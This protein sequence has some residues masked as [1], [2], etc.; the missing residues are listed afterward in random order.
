MTDDSTMTLPT[1]EGKRGRDHDT[2]ATP[3]PSPNPKDKKIP[4][5]GQG[6]KK[7]DPTASDLSEIEEAPNSA[8]S[9]ASNLATQ[10]EE[11]PVEDFQT[12]SAY[13]QV[14]EDT[15]NTHDNNQ[16]SN[17]NKNTND[18]KIKNNDDT[19]AAIAEE[20]QM[21]VEEIVFCLDFSHGFVNPSEAY[22]KLPSD[23]KKHRTVFAS[24]DV[25]QIKK[26][27]DEA[28]TTFQLPVDTLLPLSVERW[29]DIFADAANIVAKKNP[30]RKYKA[31]GLTLA[32]TH[33]QDILPPEAF[34]AGRIAESPIACA[35]GG[36]YHFFGCLWTMDKDTLI[37]WM[38]QQIA[39]TDLWKTKLPIKA[40]NLS[41][42]FKATEIFDESPTSLHCI[43]A[44]MAKVMQM[45]KRDD[46][47][48]WAVKI[49]KHLNSTGQVHL[50]RKGQGT[51]KDNFMR[52]AKTHPE[53]FTANIVDVSKLTRSSMTALWTA[54]YTT[55]GG[56]WMNP[57]LFEPVDTTDEGFTL[58]KKKPKLPS[59]LKKQSFS[60]DVKAAAPTYATATQKTIPVRRQASG[61]FLK[62]KPAKIIKKLSKGPTRKFLTF[63]KVRLPRVTKPFGPEA[64]AEV[65]QSSQNLFKII[66]K[67]D[68]R[69]VVLAYRGSGTT[70]LNKDSPALSSRSQLQLYADNVFVKQDANTWMK[71]QI[72][73]DKSR[74]EFEEDEGFQGSVQEADLWFHPDKV[75]ARSTASI[76]WL[77]GSTPDSCN[78]IDMKA[79]HE[80]HPDLGIEC[81][82]RPQNIRLYPGKNTIPAEQQVKAIHIY[83][84]LENV[85]RARRR[86]GLCYGSRNRNLANVPDK[87]LFK[88]I[89]ECSDPKFPI[90]MSH[91]SAVIRM[92]SKQK[93][94]LLSTVIIPTSTIAGLHVF[95]DEVGFTLCHILM[96][97]RLG[98]QS[99]PLFLSVTERLWGAAGYQV[100]FTVKKDRLNEANSLIPLLS[101]LIEAKFGSDARQWFTEEARI[102]SEGFY[103]DEDEQ[104]IK[105]SEDASTA[106][107]DDNFS[108]DSN[109][110]YVNNL[111]AALNLGDMEETTQGGVFNFDIDFVFDDIAPPNQYGDNGS[112][113]TFRDVCEQKSRQERLDDEAAGD[114]RAP[115]DS[116]PSTQKRFPPVSKDSKP[117][118]ID[119]N[120]THAT[121][122]STLTE[123]LPSSGT[124]EQ[125]M[126]NNPNL[127]H[128]FLLNNPQLFQPASNSTVSP[129]DGD[130]GQS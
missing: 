122:A 30:K 11:V 16:E 120:S 38:V 52:I 22:D 128:Q 62:K 43:E 86:Y 61:C 107:D 98:D 90:S 109:D 96:C 110:S 45:K 71:V 51:L 26:L 65:V 127:V 67:F 68:P 82:P 113:K 114:T 60:P 91:R 74:L 70:T 2:A 29:Q 14:H 80:A 18:N 124:L 73:H 93:H 41:I 97:L 99:I 47:E 84:A 116:P 130:D 40:R 35:L 20:D 49:R 27:I 125:M 8:N 89:P 83:V 44:S 36:A 19:H 4:K 54:I 33:P 69:A 121:P 64:E 92:M 103:W 79:S 77:L 81:E 112:V 28:P 76:G 58:V 25:E 108:I 57:R 42:G 32:G 23:L 39:P 21:S 66:W 6:G 15:T 118:A 3:K 53:V 129:T 102:T 63:F 1:S 101:V 78:I 87:Q 48:E 7:A 13:V 34:D 126:A 119:T 50:P 95:I 37:D 104:Q 17:T 75:Q 5:D 85:P 115:I 117:S 55:L 31:F 94:L 46:P 56:V 10:V 100:I 59:S 111:T 88:F 106:M 123:D 105:Q 24:S 12:K 72:A 9:K